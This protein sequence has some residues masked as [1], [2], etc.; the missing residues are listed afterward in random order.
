MDK[1]S[2]SDA[3][4]RA[5]VLKGRF[6]CS[7]RPNGRRSRQEIGIFGRRHYKAV[8]WLNAVQIGVSQ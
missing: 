4:N 5:F 8:S 2:P 6:H 7:G 3:R 1:E